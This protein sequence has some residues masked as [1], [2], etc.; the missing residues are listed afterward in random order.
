MLENDAEP[1]GSEIPY[2]HTIL[3][4]KTCQKC[5]TIEKQQL[6]AQKNGPATD[7]QTTP[8]SSPMFMEPSHSLTLKG[9]IEN[10][11]CE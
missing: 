1:L 7:Q 3:Q 5:E 4:Q 10:E 11:C 2:I 9:N 8:L 6:F